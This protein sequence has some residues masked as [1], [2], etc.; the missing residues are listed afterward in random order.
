MT[1]ATAGRPVRYGDATWPAI[2]T[3][4]RVLVTEAQRL[5]DAVE[6]V[7]TQLERLDAAASRFRADSEVCALASGRPTRVSPLLLS[8]VRAAVRAA[9]LTGGAVDPT[10][11]AGLAALG[12][13]RDFTA[14]PADSAA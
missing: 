3:T 12:Y 9:R 8:L 11:G 13:D 1:T 6:L 10:L 5:G 14:V 4:A 7:A 2:G